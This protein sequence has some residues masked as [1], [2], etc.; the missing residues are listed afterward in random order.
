MQHYNNVHFYGQ[1]TAAD[2]INALSN[3]HHGNANVAYEG[4][5]RE[6]EA[7]LKETGAET[8]LKGNK[9]KK[10]L[11]YVRFA[12]RVRYSMSLLDRSWESEEI[13]LWSLVGKQ[14]WA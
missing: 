7:N 5:A 4:G 13:T 14:T 3:A 1:L 6:K 12:S 8:Y 9:V 2:A 11:N 10:Q